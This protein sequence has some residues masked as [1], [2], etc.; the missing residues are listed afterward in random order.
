MVLPRPLPVATPTTEP[1]WAGL[2]AHKVMLQHCATCSSWVFYPRSHCPHCLSPALR[3]QQVSGEGRIYSFTIARQPTA[4][5]FAGLYTG[6]MLVDG[7]PVDGMVIAVVELN[8]GVRMN[9]V[10]V[11]ATPDELAVGLAVRPVFHPVEGDKSLNKPGTLLY[12]EIVH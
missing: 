9:T 6:G 3:W 8:E 5:Q 7:R 10:I 1:F 4:P 12:F 11:N 2:A